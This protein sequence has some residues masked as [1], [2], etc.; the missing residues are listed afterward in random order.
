MLLVGVLDVRLEKE[1]VHLGVDVLNGDLEPVE[2]AGLGDLDL[3]HKPPSEILKDNAVG[4]SEEGE[5]VRDEVPL[6]V[7]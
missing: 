4:G 5:N 6:A 3:L 7:G 1:A 2:G